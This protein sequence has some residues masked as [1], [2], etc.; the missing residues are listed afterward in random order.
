MGKKNRN[1][2][3]KNTHKS[4]KSDLSNFEVADLGD[5]DDDN[6]LDINDLLEKEQEAVH[7]NLNKKQRKQRHN[8]KVEEDDYEENSD[9]LA[10]EEINNGSSINN[11]SENI[12][13]YK[14]KESDKEVNEE[15]ELE[16]DEE[17]EEE[18]VPEKVY[19]NDKPALLELKNKMEAKFNSKFKQNEL[20]LERMTVITD[21]LINK[22]LNLN[23]DIKRELMFY[24]LAFE[25]AV[26]GI[27]GLKKHNQKL[28]RPE[29]FMAEML[30]SD[31]QMMKIKK[32]ILSHEMRIKKFQLREEKMLNKKFN[33]KTKGKGVKETQEYK[34][35]SKEAI[36]HWKRSKFIYFIYIYNIKYFNLQV[37]RKIPMNTINWMIMLIKLLEIR[38]I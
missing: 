24:N 22:N 15:E 1:N 18:E 27:N 11:K 12:L 35:T 10:E 4:N 3:F 26:K 36:E 13:H 7:Q 37:L 23:D 17:D 5:F 28:N 34:K 21:N 14:T 9:L 25:G 31:E 32:E 19:E 38:E 6:E 30:K 20:F 8:K 29:D 33:K 2:N 16:E